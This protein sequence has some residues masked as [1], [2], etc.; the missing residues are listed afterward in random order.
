M[1]KTTTS[2]LNICS[3]NVKNF[4]SKAANQLKFEYVSDLLVR[5]DFLL[6]QELW[7]LPEQLVLLDG[8]AGGC[9]KTA[10]SPMRSNV[11]RLGRPFGGVAILWKEAISAG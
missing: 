1:E 8:V 7:L 9:C 6:L 11:E 10:A 3:F 5:H 4:Q 2:S